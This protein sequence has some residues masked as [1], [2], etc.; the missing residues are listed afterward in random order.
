MF[1]VIEIQ[2]NADGTYRHNGQQP[3]QKEDEHEPA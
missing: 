3:A 2:A 1:I